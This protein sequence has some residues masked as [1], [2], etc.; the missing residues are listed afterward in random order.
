[1]EKGKGLK[2][3]AVERD[4]K[5]ETEGRRKGRGGTGKRERSEG[6]PNAFS[7]VEDNV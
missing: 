2:M 3:E 4:G 7:Q 5:G 1:M 6:S